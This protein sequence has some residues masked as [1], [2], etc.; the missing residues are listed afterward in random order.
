MGVNLNCCT[1]NHNHMDVD[2]KNLYESPDI[3]QNME[4]ELIE[5]VIETFNF[6]DTDKQALQL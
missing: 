4:N 6:K 3:S 2:L 1:S 5:S